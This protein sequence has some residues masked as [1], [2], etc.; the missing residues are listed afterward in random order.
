MLRPIMVSG[1]DLRP[2][3]RLQA[4]AVKSIAALPDITDGG[5]R[6]VKLKLRS[7]TKCSSTVTRI[8]MRI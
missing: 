2:M 6:T 3:L 1:I 7:P 5:S 4:Y 8:V